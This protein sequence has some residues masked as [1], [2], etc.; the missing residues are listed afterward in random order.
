MNSELWIISCILFL[1]GAVFAAAGAMLKYYG[2]TLEKYDGHT[3]GRVV[4]IIQEPRTGEASRSEFRNHQV[5]VIEFFAGGKPVKVKARW[6]AYRSPYILNQK[7]K[8][9]YN[10]EN[11]QEYHVQRPNK[12]TRWGICINLIGVADILAG[13]LLFL[14]FASGV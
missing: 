4:D 5:A 9:R 6:D 14:L 8:I 3:E 11:P 1:L 2:S 7:L 12:W 10:T 13:C